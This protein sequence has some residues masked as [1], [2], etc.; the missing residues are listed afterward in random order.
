MLM[1]RRKLERLA[2]IL[3]SLLKLIRKITTALLI[4]NNDATF[5]EKWW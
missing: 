2:L 4:M 5:K 3:M 1:G